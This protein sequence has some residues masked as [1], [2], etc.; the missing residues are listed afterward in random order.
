MRPSAKSVSVAEHMFPG[1]LADAVASV[2]VEADDRTRLSNEACLDINTC[3]VLRLARCFHEVA[4][5][6]RAHSPLEPLAPVKLPSLDTRDEILFL[7]R[8]METSQKECWLEWA[9]Q[10]RQD[11]S[12]DN[13][14]TNE[15][16]EIKRA[17]DAIHIFH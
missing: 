13:R 4:R 12:P 15:I 14:K 17:M 2:M 16:N 7:M 9:D 3:E 11:Q 5:L 8:P 6:E 1:G 10:R